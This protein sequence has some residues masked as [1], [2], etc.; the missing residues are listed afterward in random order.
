MS[1]VDYGLIPILCNHLKTNNVE[2]I[3]LVLDSIQLILR[4][5]AERQAEVCMKVEECGGKN[6]G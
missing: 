3:L 2:V 4:K 5:S 1:L 6:Y